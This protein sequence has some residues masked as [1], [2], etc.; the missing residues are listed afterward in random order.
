MEFDNVETI[1]RSVEAGLGVS[2]LPAP[3]LASET[4]RT[5]VPGRRPGA[6]LPADRPHAPAR[7]RAVADQPR[8]RRA[9]HRRVAR[10]RGTR[11]ER[12][13]RARVLE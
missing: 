2:I 11:R 12:R 4:A 9:P 8:L 7:P 5:L 1:K 6:V 10:H 13:A 3:T